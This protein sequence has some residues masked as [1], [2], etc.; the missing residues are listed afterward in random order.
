[1]DRGLAEP[2]TSILHTRSRRNKRRIRTNYFEGL[3][4]DHVDYD[5][6]IKKDIYPRYFSQGFR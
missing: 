2:L 3:I 4:T 1:M 6:N 5:H